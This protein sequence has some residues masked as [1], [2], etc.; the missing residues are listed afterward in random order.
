M[1]KREHS[2]QHTAHR[3]Y[4]VHGTVWRHGD[5]IG[6]WHRYSCCHTTESAHVQNTY[7]KEDEDKTKL[8]RVKVSRA[9]GPSLA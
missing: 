3:A 4:G 8:A 2:T 7:R 6:L 5:G 1:Y 9:L